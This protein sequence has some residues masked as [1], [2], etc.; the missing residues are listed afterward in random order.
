[1]PVL[2]LPLTGLAGCELTWSPTALSAV[3]G[4]L[5]SL[6]F[7]H[8]FQPCLD[9]AHAAGPLQGPAAACPAPCCPFSFLDVGGRSECSNEPKDWKDAHLCCSLTS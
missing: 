5:P 4:R 1:M 2:K 9:W 3:R 7:V 6:I 8:I